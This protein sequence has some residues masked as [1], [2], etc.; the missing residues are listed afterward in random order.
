MITITLLSLCFLAAVS[1]RIRHYQ[2][3][4]LTA[5]LWYI[6]LFFAV[7][8]AI[9]VILF[10]NGYVFKG[11][12]TGRVFLS[13]YAGSGMV[14]YSL[15]AEKGTGRKAYLALFYSIP[16][17]LLGGLL[18]PPLRLFT[19]VAAIWLLVDGEFKR[20]PIDDEYKLQIRNTAVINSRYPTYSLVQGRYWLFEKVT[21]DVITP[22]LNASDVRVKRVSADSIQL[23]LIS[24]RQQLDTVIL[25]N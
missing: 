20:Y 12:Y 4:S 25:V 23:H 22:H 5:A 2:D 9:C 21:E 18:L 11:V 19:T 1:I 16:F 17:I 24:D 7:L 10:L 14:L 3:R 6:H 8:S 13:L 15:T